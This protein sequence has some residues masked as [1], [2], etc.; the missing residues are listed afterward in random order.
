MHF[1]YSSIG[2]IIVFISTTVLA[3]PI[4]HPSGASLTF[5]GIS[6]RTQNVSDMGNPAQAAVNYAYENNSIY[7]AGISMGLGIE[8][9]G[10][11]NFFNLLDRI[12]ADDAIADGDGDG[13]GDGSS[14]GDDGKPGITIPDI[15]NPD[16]QALLDEVK[17]TATVIAAT[18]A[19][20]TTGL[21]AKAY[22]TADAP[23]V[24]SNNT[25]G[26]SWAFGLNHSI[27]TNI[28]GL[29]EPINFDI[30]AAV[31]TL[32]A[33]YLAPA[34]A[35]R[36]AYKLPG[37]ITLFVNGDGTTSYQFE[38]NSGVITRAAKITE[39]SISYSRPVWT[40]E[41][42]RLFVGIKPKLYDVGLSN[43]AVPIANIEDAK[44]IFDTL[45]D[46]N[47]KHTNSLGLD[48]GLVFTGNQYQLGATLTNI[49]EPE[50]HYPSFK[51]DGF[52]NPTIISAIRSYELYTMERQLK[53]EAGYVTA[54]GAWRLN[55]GVDANAVPDPMGDNYQWLSVGAAYVADS[56]WLPGARVGA[57]HNLAGA[58]LSYLTAGVTLFKI[59]NVDLASTTETIKVD[60]DTVP[61]GLIANVGV[62]VYF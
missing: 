24:I 10:N 54:S 38:N 21:N 34:P 50:F 59:L 41:N 16:I 4:Y 44:T 15:N 11:D 5:G 18:L 37:D 36:D 40:K 45:D 61:R 32:Q 23:I 14:P 27:T 25:L 53:L 6:S 47:F 12:G 35:T 19:I 52:T 33:D 22:V 2:L 51:L 56:W 39:L 1:T 13:S 42:N 58:E 28:V 46:S 31:A 57:R 26:G 60:G 9:D 55:A 62:Q 17:T 20:A 3:E 49:N 43:T 29:H 7:G 30:D 48:A 8:Y